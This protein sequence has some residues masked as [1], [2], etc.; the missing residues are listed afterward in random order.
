M[1]AHWEARGTQDLR[2][3]LGEEVGS[4]GQGGTGK[5]QQMSG[6]MFGEAI[7]LFSDS[8]QELTIL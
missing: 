6:V 7:V 4:R 2:A 8:R 3:N 1:I 5:Q